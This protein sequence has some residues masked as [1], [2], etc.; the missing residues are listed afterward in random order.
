MTYVPSQRIRRIE[1]E[2]SNHIPT[3]V[4]AQ[5]GRTPARGMPVD[6][7]LKR[8]KT[9]IL[10]DDN[11]ACFVEREKALRESADQTLPLP[12]EERYAFQ[13][14][15][16]LERLSTP[17]TVEEV[18]AGRAIEAV[19]E[20]PQAA[21][22]V[23]GG[24]GSQGHMTLNWETLLRR[25]L[26]A[27]TAE[28]ETNA[29]RIG[30][31]AALEFAANARNCADAIAAF[32]RH[33]AQTARGLAE[34]T[35]AAA[36]R[37][38]LTRIA[39]ALEEVPMGPAKDFFSALQSIWMVHFLTSCVIGARDFAFGHLDYYLLPY[40]EA[41]LARG[42]LDREAATDPMAHFLLKSNEIT[43]TATWN[44]KSPTE[45]QEIINRTGY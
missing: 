31:P 41:D 22:P 45:Q 14:R 11:A 1:A 5:S 17:L 35:R 18:F 34:Q 10:Q 27:I 3:H 43:G 24:L 23:P 26:D 9:R 8:L 2:T 15:F 29:V 33:Y 30:T 37:Q 44:Y 39:D 32:V 19:W 6:R 7:A 20:R 36:T 40:P 12:L 4:F 25:G 38:R 16:V 21:P 28:A 13:L 42:T